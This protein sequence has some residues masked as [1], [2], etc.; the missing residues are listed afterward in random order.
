MVNFGGTSFDAKIRGRYKVR[1]DGTGTARIC[2]IPENSDP[3]IESEIAFVVTGCNF[4][5]IQMVTT[6]M[7]SCD[8]NSDVVVAI[9]FM[10]SVSRMLFRYDNA[11]HHLEIDSYPYHKHTPD[12]IVPSTIPS[13]KDILNEISAII[14]GR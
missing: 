5:E 13:I 6:K 4:D 2:S 1:S 3:G 7:T 9:P 8:D 10:N 14:I 11:P 12:K